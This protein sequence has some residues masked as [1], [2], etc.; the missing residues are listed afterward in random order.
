MTTETLTAVLLEKRDYCGWPAYWL[1]RGELELAIAPAAGGRILRV[2]WRGHDLAYANPAYHG[3]VLDLQSF[4]DPRAA[5]REFGLRRYGGDHTWLAPQSRWSDGVPF[6]DLDS[7]A[8]QASIDQQTE[9]DVR[10]T[11]T[12]PVDRETGV[13]V[14][15]TV[16]LNA[17]RAGFEITHTLRN[18][19]GKLA[20]WAIWDVF[21]L[22]RPGRVY[23]PRRKASR[24]PAGVK[25]VESDA[26][27]AAAREAA[28]K[29]TGPIV[30]VDCS[31]D[32]PF[33]FGVDAD[34]GWVLALQPA[35]SM[36]VPASSDA[37]GAGEPSA[38]PSSADASIES[39]E[40]PADSLSG[41]GA[42]S[43]SVALVGYA[44]AYEVFGRRPYGNS[45]TAEVSHGGA[46]GPYF[47]IDVHGPLTLLA[48][49]QQ[50]QLIE[51]RLLFDAT[52]SPENED[53]IRSL[54]ANAL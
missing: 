5:K 12:S 22:R 50:A 8:Y 3:R 18:V 20:Q 49:G 9:Q 25:S 13:Q 10:L 31:G 21:H 43:P 38:E 40:S 11:V 42:S 34:Q 27:S 19:S 53:Q 23:L 33:R 45:C 54:I 41:N 29:T 36:Y 39:P 4:P 30:I 14:T 52:S 24:F 37:P 35:G 17:A 7:G 6:L 48:P 46:A 32:A 15:R 2:A 28:L 51:Q 26:Q 16:R 44:T 47:A 1:R